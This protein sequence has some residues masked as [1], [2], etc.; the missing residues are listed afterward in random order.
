M[1]GPGGN[2][3]DVESHEQD[4]RAPPI[5][6]HEARRIAEDV[7]GRV[8]VDAHLLCGERPAQQHAREEPNRDDDEDHEDGEPELF[9]ELTQEK[10]DSDDDEQD[11]HEHDRFEHGRTEQGQRSPQRAPDGPRHRDLPVS[12]EAIQCDRDG[13]IDHKHREGRRPESER[14]VAE[15]QE[16]ELD[17]LLEA[18]DRVKDN[19]REEAKA[20]E[21]PSSSPVDLP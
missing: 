15:W 19:D 4:C 3:D 16:G 10:R 14:D 18:R 17:K 21:Q 7:E 9:Y 20:E 5:A 11:K 12:V 13:S 8:A 1:I 2:G 6:L